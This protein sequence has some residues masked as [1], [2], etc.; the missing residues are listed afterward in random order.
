MQ[1]LETRLVEQ[2][3]TVL[4]SLREDAVNQV[5]MPDEST[6][7]TEYW[8]TACVHISGNWQGVVSAECSYAMAV[9]VAAAMFMMEPDELSEDEVRDALGEVANLLAGQFKLDLPEGCALSL[10]TVTKG[11]DYL[12]NV[13]GSQLSQ[14]VGVEQGDRCMVVSVFERT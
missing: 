9:E 8:T 4:S 13:P 3:E 1:V 11:L 7:G 10:P 6:R 2:V 5:D 12:I 14:R